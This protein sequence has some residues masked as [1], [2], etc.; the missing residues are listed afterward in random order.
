MLAMVL[1]PEWQ[2]TDCTAL[3]KEQR[4]CETEA[5]KTVV[6]LDG[7]K[8][9][10]CPR[11]IMLDQPRFVSEVWWLFSRY[12]DGIL[13]EHGGLYDQPAKYLAAMRTLESARAQADSEKEEKDKRRSAIQARANRILEG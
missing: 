13:P 12:V 4:G 8:L 10:R 3:Q 2:C 1:L 5:K 6:E 7:A 11:R 9:K